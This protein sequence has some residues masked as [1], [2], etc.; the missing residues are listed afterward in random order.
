MGYGTDLIRMNKGRHVM[1][2]IR[3]QWPV[4]QGCFASG[5]IDADGDAPLHY[6]YDCGARN[7]THLT[8][9]VSHYTER[10][11]NLHALFVS[12]LDSDHVDGLDRLLATMSTDTVYLPYLDVVSRTLAVMQADAEDRLTGTYL[13]AE[14]RPDQWFGSRGVGRVVFVQN[15]GRPPEDGFVPREPDRPKAPEKETA[16]RLQEYGTIPSKEFSFSSSNTRGGQIFEM[17][18]GGYI[19]AVSA[20][21]TSW[22]L[23]PYVPPV[24]QQ[25]A[26]EF[27][28]R[29]RQALN[30]GANARLTADR[31]V[32]QLRTKPGRR[33]LRECY[34]AIIDGGATRNH[35][36]VSMSLY[37]GP[38]WPGQAR[39]PVYN[40]CNNPAF[41]AYM[42]LEPNFPGWLGTGD[43]KLK[44]DRTRRLWLDFYRNLAPQVGTLLL[45]HHG[46]HRNWHADLPDQLPAR[47]FI[48]AADDQ[49]AGYRHP[50]PGVVLDIQAA[51]KTLIHVTKDLYTRFSETIQV[52]P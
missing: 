49:D 4:G 36:H 20:N 22:L 38:G 13:E 19:E 48:A 18:V 16:T 21:Q 11:D 17:Q 41:S 26:K 52:G 46:S 1:K 3:D 51:H 34:S 7:L 45:P 8:P 50:S 28:A 6:V 43:A 39:G 9:I 14:M 29:V 24:D 2:V 10:T 35:N 47:C 44:D 42:G 15:Q 37:S 40:Y 30:L 5:I 27:R 25:R 33:A 31:I 32:Q 23:V 12:H